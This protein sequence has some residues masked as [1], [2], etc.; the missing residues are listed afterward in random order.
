MTPAAL[1]VLE[2]GRA[3]RGWEVLWAQDQWRQD[4]LPHGDLASRHRGQA[5]LHFE[6]LQQPWLKEA[7]KRWARRRLLAGTAPQSLACY[8]G[9][10]RAFSAWLKEHAPE[11]RGPAGLTRG[12]LED[13]LLWVRTGPQKTATQQRLVGSLRMLLDEQRDDG[14]AGLPVGARILRTEAPR[15][16]YRLPP[17]LEAGVFAQLI[18]PANL[19]RLDCEQHRTIVLLLAFCG[20]RVSSVVTLP[21]G[22]LIR[23]EDGHPYLRYANLKLRREAMLPIPPQLEQQLDRQERYL[24]DRYPEGTRW[25][26]P[27]PPVG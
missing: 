10:L 26:L 6:N 27:S 17:Q 3:P 22:A 5:V 14:L 11:L 9:D 21:R 15:V 24:T 8:L 25:L 18:D 23:G 1:Q 16:D 13:F 12:V 2:G 4:E 20:L 19:A 7:A